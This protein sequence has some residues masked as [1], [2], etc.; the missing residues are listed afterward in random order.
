[1]ATDITYASLAKSFDQS[2]VHHS[3]TLT[4]M[5]EMATR[6]PSN[7]TEEQTTA[8]NRMALFPDKAEILFVSS[9]IW[10]VCLAVYT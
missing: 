2:L 9:D 5:A 3:E 4:R 7:P 10:A 8:R 6:R 1:V